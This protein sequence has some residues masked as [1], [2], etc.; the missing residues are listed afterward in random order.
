MAGE[1][2]IE[3][4]FKAESKQAIEPATFGAAKL[5]PSLNPFLLGYHFGRSVTAAP[6]ATKSIPLAPEKSGPFDE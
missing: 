1:Y 4:A 5:V 6:G 2:G 3:F